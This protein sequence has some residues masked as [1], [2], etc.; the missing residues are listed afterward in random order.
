MAAKR[1]ADWFTAANSFASFPMLWWEMYWA[2]AETIGYRLTAMAAGGLNPS[3]TQRRENRRMVTE[4]LDAGLETAQIL[5]APP[6]LAWNPRWWRMG[7]DL[8]QQMLREFQRYQSLWQWPW[9]NPGQTAQTLD[10]AIRPWHRRV[11]AN[12][13]RLRRA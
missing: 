5:F 9:L 3:A 12:A 4:K 2:A 8:S 10:R 11:T 7:F 1:S 13:K 6:T